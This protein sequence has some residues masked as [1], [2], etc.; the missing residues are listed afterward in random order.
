MIGAAMR[1]VLAE[2]GLRVTEIEFLGGWAL[3]G[4]AA[5]VERQPGRRL[6]HELRVL[7]AQVG[8]LWQPATEMLA[9]VVMGLPGWDAALEEVKGH[10]A[11]ARGN[12]VQAAARFRAAADGFRDAGQPLD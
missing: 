10:L 5:S 9:T 1:A 6:Q 2:T 4:D 12:D 8:V 11:L 7:G 3:D